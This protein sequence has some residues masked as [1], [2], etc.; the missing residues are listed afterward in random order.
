MAAENFKPEEIVK[1]AKETKEKIP[2]LEKLEY[3]FYKQ[4]FISKAKF[5]FEYGQMIAKMEKVYK[6]DRKKY[7]EIA[8]RPGNE[9]QSAF[10]IYLYE[11]KNKAAQLEYGSWQDIQEKALQK[12]FDNLFSAGDLEILSKSE[13]TAHG[14]IDIG[15][16]NTM[17]AFNIQ[18]NKKTKE[19]EVTLGYG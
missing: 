7:E 15:G 1:P 4:L 5:D 9:G 12:H 17:S 11:S 14:R 6:Y 18:L 8:A 13:K 16:N 3:K 10:E 2:T 19:I